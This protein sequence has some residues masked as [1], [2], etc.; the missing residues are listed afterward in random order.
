VT[1]K[2]TEA[3]RRI[4][5]EAL[6][7]PDD[8]SAIAQQTSIRE[9]TMLDLVRAYLAEKAQPGPATA[10]TGVRTGAEIV[11]DKR[12]VPHIK[13]DNAWDLFFGFGYAQAQ[14]RLWQLDYLLRHAPRGL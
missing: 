5:R 12:G 6:A 10:K 8:L 1:T 13:A 7:A 11:R 2:L 4:A 9:A 3:G 14:D